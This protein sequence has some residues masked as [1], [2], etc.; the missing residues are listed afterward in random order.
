[1]SHRGAWLN[2]IGVGNP[3]SFSEMNQAMASKRHLDILQQQSKEE[4]TNRENIRKQASANYL[5]NTLDK[6]DFLSGSPYDPMI[7]QG[8]DNAMKQGM[9]LASKGADTPTIM[10]AIGPLVGRLNQYQQTAKQIDASIKTS[11]EKRKQFPGYNA[12]ALTD[13]AKKAAYFN[14]DGTMKDISQVDPNIDYTNQVLQNSPDKVTTSQGIDEFVNKTPLSEESKEIQTMHKGLKKNLKYDI[15][16]NYWEGVPED[17]NGNA[18][19]DKMGQPVGVDVKSHVLTAKDGKPMIDPGTNEPFRV[20]NDNEFKGVISRSPAIADYINGQVIKH[21]KEAGGQVAPS[22]G[23]PEWEDMAKHIL[24]QELKTR[25]RASFKQRDVETTAPLRTRIELT[26]SAFAPK[27]NSN[28]TGDVQINDVYHSILTNPHVQA[29][30]AT[31]LNKLSATEQGVILS[32]AR[33]LTKDEKLN[34]EDIYVRKDENDNVGIYDRPTGKLISTI[35]A[36][37][38]NLKANKTVKPQ[39]KILQQESEPKYEVEGKKYSE[40][41]IQKGAA[42]YKMTVEQYKKELGIK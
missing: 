38:V 9:E 16:R 29:N 42:H 33:D 31:Q 24:Y 4:K 7:V 40:S 21:F 13:E 17:G 19:V 32:H 37:D 22:V 41:Q 34:Q 8:L 6:K 15:K 18:M 2:G 10:M 12:D 36:K 27:S 39:Q 1:M 11:V 26:G 25:S 30:E 3:I 14:A 28:K 20:M 5:Q 35:D 23:S